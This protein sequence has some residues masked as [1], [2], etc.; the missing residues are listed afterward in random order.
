MKV[1]KQ[2]YLL[3]VL[4]I[5]FSFSSEYKPCTNQSEVLKSIKEVSSKSKT[6]TSDF[7]EEKK[8]S[9][10]TEPQK[11]SGKFY[12]D[13][14]GKMRWEQTEPSTYIILINGQDLKIKEGNKEKDLDGHKK[15][16]LQI[17]QFM[18]NLVS[19]DYENLK[20]VKTSVLESASDY[21]VLLIPQE[22]NLSKIYTSISLMFNKKT[23]LLEAIE[24]L[25]S[26]GDTRKMKF[27]NTQYNQ[28]ISDQKFTQF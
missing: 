11:S 26:N 16:V 21:K 23:Y 6:I 19:G 4:G 7:A 14:N 12:Y 8:L 3:V 9:F 17:N 18:M 2:I 20:S 24:F 22:K 27:V 13:K 1:F 15:R 28:V 5:L 25:E 10:L